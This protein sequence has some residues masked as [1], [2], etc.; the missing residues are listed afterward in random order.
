MLHVDHYG[1]LVNRH[2]NDRGVVYF[3]VLFQLFVVRLTGELL[4]CMRRRRWFMR[5]TPFRR[6]SSPRTVAGLFLSL[7]DANPRYTDREMPTR[8][9]PR[10]RTVTCVR[11]VAAD[12][13][14]LR[15]AGQGRSS[16]TH[17][18]GVDRRQN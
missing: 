3:D 5:T 6:R 8:A 13:R 11:R 12:R 4:F 18:N 10:R 7:R 16:G 2:K 1:G 9:V 15:R 17:D 14:L